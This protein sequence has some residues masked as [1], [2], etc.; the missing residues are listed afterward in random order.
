M[1][2]RIVNVRCLW[3]HVFMSYYMIQWRGVFGDGGG[4]SEILTNDFFLK[5]G[6]SQKY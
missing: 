5:D 2:K 4:D 3:I 6:V 1:K